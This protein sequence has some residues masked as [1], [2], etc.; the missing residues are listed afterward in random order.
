ML[1]STGYQEHSMKLSFCMIVVN[2][3]PFIKYNL[4]SLYPH[5]HEIIIVEG[6]VKKYKHAAT[7]DGHSIDDTVNVIR[8]YPDPDKKIKLIQRHGFWSEKV[9][10]SNAYM[11]I[12][13]GDYVWQVDVDEFYKSEDIEKI[14]C[15]LTEN[16]RVTRLDLQTINFSHG[17][18]SIMKGASYSFGADKFRRIFKFKP[19]FRFLTHRPPKVI[20]N[21]GKICSD[22][23]VVSAEELVD[24]L[25][26]YMY[27]YSYI[28]EKSVKSKA[29]YYSQMDWGR[30]CEEGTKWAE[31]VWANLTNPLRVHLIDFPP[32]WIVKFQGEHPVA[33]QQLI[34]D[35][36]Y[37]ENPIV[38]DYLQDRGEKFAKIGEYICTI[39][40]DVEKKKLNKYK[41]AV[42]VFKQLILP[43]NLQELNADLTILKCAKK[44]IN[45]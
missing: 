10:M 28:F 23:N 8:E 11:E 6:A 41:A 27:H 22:S 3:E 19:G 15:F 5:A 37:R 35:L 1:L 45:T 14:R 42:M 34:G 17:F 18:E 21:D 30:G 33:V 12:C 13:T 38:A 26:V 44:L 36:D 31:K 4:D 24:R 29:H 9:E 32:S 16:T 20:N 43:K 25:G 2:G 7:P 39:C 40:G